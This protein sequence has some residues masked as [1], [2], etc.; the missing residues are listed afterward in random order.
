MQ[1]APL[2]VQLT[3][4]FCVSFVT[5]A[6]TLCVF[7]LCTDALVG[8]TDTPTAGGAVTVIVAAAVLLVSATDFAV[9]VTIAGAGTLAGAVYVIAAPDAL[10]AADNV[11]QAAPVQPAPVNVQVTPLFWVSFVTVAVTPWVFPLST[12]A[13][14]GFTDTPTAGGAVTVIANAAVLLVSATDFAVSVTVAGDGTLAGAVYVIATPDALDAADNVPQAAPVQPAPVKVHVTL[15]SCVSFVTVAVT[16]WVFPLSTDALVGFTDTPTAGGTVT[17]I[18]NAAVLVVSVTDFAVSVTIAGAG[19]LAGAEYIIAAPDAL[20]AADN[21][22]QLAPVHPAPLNVHVTPAFCA[23]FFTVAVTLSVFPLCTAAVTGDTDTAISAITV[24]CAVSSAEG[25]ACEIA[26]M[27]TVGG[28]G[29]VLGAVYV[30]A[31]SIVPC[32]ASPPATPFTCQVTAMLEVFETW[33]LNFIVLEICTEALAGS[34]MIDTLCCA[35]D[36]IWPHPQI[37]RTTSKSSAIDTILRVRPE[38]RESMYIFPLDKTILSFLIRKIEK[39][40]HAAAGIAVR[41][42][43]RISWMF[44]KVKL[45]IKVFRHISFPLD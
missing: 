34:T 22:P 42:V 33:T 15:L 12:D 13:L 1:P 14:V 45:Q 21:V 17:V 28:V 40:S 30:P 16:L 10:D 43:E 19:T 39:A 35:D 20:D 25:C 6:V 37:A 9:S 27:V 29:T 7:P 31:A 38:L 41:G 24:T 2:N 32:A 5:V 26:V 23:S 36:W 18:A 11:P 44:Q 3:P 8:F 4:L